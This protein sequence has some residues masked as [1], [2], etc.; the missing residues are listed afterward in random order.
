[1]NRVLRGLFGHKGCGVIGNWL[2]LYNEELHSLRSSAH[3]IKMNTSWRIRWIEHVP[4]MR[5]KWN[6]YRILVVT[7]EGKYH[8][9]DLDV[10]E[11]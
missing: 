9:E 2:K 7:P 10:G 5:E 8:Y 3:I 6:A 4:R 11:K 1:V